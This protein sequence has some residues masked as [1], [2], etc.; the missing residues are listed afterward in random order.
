MSSSTSTL[1]YDIIARDRASSTF[2]KIGRAAGALGVG[3]GAAA[4]LKFGKDSVMAEAEFSQSMASVQVNAKIGER[5]LGSLSD[6]AM[7]LG[8]DTVYS[9]NEAAQAMLELSKGGMT[10]AQ[11]K[12]GA[13]KST[14][15]LAATEG[16]AL[17]DSAT[18]VART[19][20]TFGLGADSANKAVDMLAGGSLASTAGVQDLAD[21]LK[22]VGTTA[23]SSGYGLS[24]TVTALAALT[25]SGISSTTAGSALNRML[26]GLTL[27]TDKA[28]KTA[29][30]LGLSF[31]DAKGNLLPMIDVVKQLQDTFQG[32]STSQR[33]NDLKK[34]FGVEGMRAANVLIEQGVDGWKKYKG[35]VDETGQAAKMADARM[36]GTE[37]A[38]EQL[39]GSIET[40]Q[41]KLGKALAPA[42]QDVANG[43]ADNL[44]PAMDGAIDLADDLVGAAVPL[45]DVL[46]LAGGAAADAAGFFMDLPGPVKSLVLQAGLAAA[47]FPRV[48]SAIGGAASAMRNGSTY[49]RVL[50]LE[51]T[52]VN[53][54]GTAASSAMTKLGGVARQAGGVGGMLLLAHGAQETDQK[55]GGLESAAGGAL[56][57]FAAG[58]PWGAA[59]GAGAGL[60]MGLAGSTDSAAD[61]AKQAQPDFEGLAASLNQVTGATTSA[62]R[63][64]IYD[65]LTRSGAMK[66]MQ[67]YGITQRQAVDAVMG[68]ADAM[69]AIQAISASATAEYRKNEAAIAAN[70]AEI[71]RLTSNTADMTVEDYDAVDALHQKNGVL[72]ETNKRL[73]AETDLI[74]S[75]IGGL[76]KSQKAVRDK[77]AAVA[78]LN[79]LYKGLPKDVR[80]EL[81]ADGIPKTAADVKALI[82]QYDLTPK[83]VQSLFKAAGID[84]SIADIRRLIAA[85]QQYRDKTVTITTEYRSLHTD[86]SG[87]TRGRP[88]DNMPGGVTPR[89][90]GGGTNPGRF[91]AGTRGGN[92]RR[93]PLTRSD[94]DGVEIRVTGVDPGM[95]AFLYTGGSSRYP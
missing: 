23:R 72:Q 10:A 58:G 93:S 92:G 71:E 39:S 60:L 50:A 52:D 81:K 35:A 16:I 21:A 75:E 44:G 5:A 63:A 40:A 64:Q 24:D 90:G 69:H 70:N 95:K 86:G 94:L 29:D 56:M 14:L 4:I 67:K 91:T 53:T 2:S 34:I 66:T 45:V 22:Y 8:Q 32:L 54:R 26:L 6:M 43:L 33:N 30:S 28:S 12:A 79:Q 89:T 49:A 55:L 3:L 17:G 36:S 57:G 61:A 41:I 20:K 68:H 78:S 19:L 25:D 13:L 82:A 85:Q 51:L 83:Q 1:A 84:K 76:R 18:I 38:L 37:G 47:I 27:G 11:I 7:R 31:T 48:S 46:K 87:P 65:D 77:A 88:D 59:I 62:T 42:V 80:T 74:D 9:A 73:A 15:N